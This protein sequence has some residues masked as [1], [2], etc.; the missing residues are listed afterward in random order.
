MCYFSLL[1][2]LDNEVK[3][4]SSVCDGYHGFSDAF[5]I[6]ILLF[7]IFMV[8]N[9]SVLS[10]D[11]TL[12]YIFL[13]YIGHIC[14]KKVWF[15]WKKLN[16]IAYNFFLLIIRANNKIIYFVE[17][18][19]KL[20]ENSRNRYHSVNSKIKSKKYKNNEETLQKQAWINSKNLLGEEKYKK[21]KYVRNRYKNLPEQVKQKR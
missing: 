16:I 10:L 13:I 21:R 1:V 11:N 15:E 12:I 7:S 17:N 14:I 6:A 8:L 19:E 4:Q 3:F 9:I 5:I 20:K 18:K 2:F